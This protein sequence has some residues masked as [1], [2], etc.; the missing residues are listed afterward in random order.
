M[1]DTV[2][3]V[4]GPTWP[5]NGTNAF[6]NKREAMRRAAHIRRM[7]RAYH[8]APAK[9]DC[10]LTIETRSRRDYLERVL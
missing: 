10:G 8:G 5:Y 4:V 3:V 6:Y 2:Y 7:L 1:K 9:G